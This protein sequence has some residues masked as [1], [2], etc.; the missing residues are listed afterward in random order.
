MLIQW[1][2]PRL[3][4]KEDEEEVSVSV[5]SEQETPR[6]DSKESTSDKRVSPDSA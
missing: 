5:R 2:G 1:L 6:L 3:L 4:S